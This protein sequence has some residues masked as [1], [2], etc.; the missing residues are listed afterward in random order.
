M[1]EVEV[2]GEFLAGLFTARGMSRGFQRER[3][4]SRDGRGVRSYERRVSLGSA[5]WRSLE[6]SMSRARALAR[7]QCAQ[8]GPHMK[9]D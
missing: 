9:G 8:T 5:S 6:R 1:V 2:R 7:S 4:L 3:E